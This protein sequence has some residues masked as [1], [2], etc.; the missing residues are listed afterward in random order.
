[1]EK[2]LI[3]ESVLNVRV[4]DEDSRFKGDGG[5]VA[6]NKKFSGKLED[7]VLELNEYFLLKN[8]NSLIHL[9]TGKYIFL[10]IFCFQN[11]KAFVSLL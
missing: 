7:I 3:E 8:I 11:F 6:I 10:S 5:F 1:M 2:Y 4:F 9:F